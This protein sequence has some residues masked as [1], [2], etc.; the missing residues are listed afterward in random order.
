MVERFLQHINQEGLCLE[1]D[2]ILVAVSGGADSVVMLD[3]FLKNGFTVG[4]AHCN[5][6][7]RGEESDEDEAF[8]QHLAQKN[9]LP[10]FIGQFE[11]E[12]H[13]AEQ[14]ISIQMAARE[15]RYTWFEDVSRDHEYDRIAT[16]HNLNDS[17]ETAVFNFIKG[18][19]LKGLTGIPPRSGK[20]IRPLLFVSREEI[21]TYAEQEGL[22][23]RTDSSNKGIKYHRNFIRHRILPAFEKV[24]PGFQATVRNTLSRLKGVQR[25]LDSWLEERKADYLEIRGKDIYLDKKFFA[26]VGEPAILYEVIAPYGFSYSQCVLIYY[27]L[28][29]RSGGLFYAGHHVLNNDRRHLIISPNENDAEEYRIKENENQVIGRNGKLVLE[30]IDANHEK[31]DPDPRVGYFDMDKL[32]FPLI[33]RT[34]DAGDWFIPL[35]MKGKKKLSDFMIDKK[36]PLNLKKRLM[37]LSSGGAIVWVAGHRTDE[38]FKIRD[39]TRK[40]LKIT[41]LEWDD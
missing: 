2:T 20:I 41:Y 5:F 21:E 17:V 7:L 31:I 18:T 32:K 12:K 9:N 22:E 3:L 29:S 38:R 36:I 6:G 37:V 10:L 30:Y 28:G 25:F 16:G 34:W 35:G 4:V 24:N 33:F 15:L 39:N 1:K 23:Y 27:N 40:I 13:A 11:T 14:G 19:G 26:D 8:V